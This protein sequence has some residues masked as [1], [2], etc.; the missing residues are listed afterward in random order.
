MKP[1]RKE[2]IKWSPDLAYVV[3]LITTDGNLSIDGRHIE[4]TS[5]DGQLVKTFKKYLN[6]KVK[7]RT[8]SSGYSNKRY[9][10]I[11]FGDVVLYRW[12]LKI[13]L[14]PHKS[15]TISSLEIPNRYFFDFLRGCFDGDGTI[16]S[17]WD[18]RWRSSFMF[19]TAF[20]SG[21]LKFLQW[22][23]NKINR[24]LDLNGHIGNSGIRGNFILRYAKGDTLVLFKKMF[25]SK[26]I[27]FLRR[28]YEKALKIFQINTNHNKESL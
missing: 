18:H 24:N 6:L 1:R 4:F 3:G 15:K 2:K 20:S 8:K 28:K 23:K 25:S 9:P 10:H 7:I 27:P 26:N 19:Y 21:S 17:Y 14:T 5:K 11:Q 13:G 22:L 16:F 12:L